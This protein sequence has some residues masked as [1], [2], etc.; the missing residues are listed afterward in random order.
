MSTLADPDMTS[1]LMRYA[2]ELDAPARKKL[3][4]LAEGSIGIALT[5]A[6]EGGIAI[7]G[8]VDEVLAA[9]VTPA[10]AQTIAE[11]V[12][13]TT[14]GVDKFSTFFTLLRAGIAATTRAAARQ[15]TPFLANS[16]S[17]WQEIGRIEGQAAG[18]NLD[19]RAAVI[20][21]LSQLHGT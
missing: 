5:L 19:K 15:G 4:G 13:R 6:A 12:T 20:V 7:A 8:L 2:P 16:V 3:I 9:P 21:A 18:L 10:R 17:L 14:E 1:L 11:A